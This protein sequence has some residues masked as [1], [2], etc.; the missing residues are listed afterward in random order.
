[1]MNQTQAVQFLLN[2]KNNDNDD[3]RR[4]IQDVNTGILYQYYC[5]E[6]ICDKINGQQTG[7]VNIPE[8]QYISVE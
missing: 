4:T 5:G 2:D 1:M 7:V 6:F 3:L 8:G